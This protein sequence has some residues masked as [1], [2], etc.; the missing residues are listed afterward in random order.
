MMSNVIKVPS[1]SQILASLAGYHRGTLVFD[2]PDRYRQPY[3]AVGLRRAAT[4]V[5]VDVL[6]EP[7]RGG[8]R[9]TVRV[10]F[11]HRNGMPLDED[12]LWPPDLEISKTS[13]VVV[14]SSFFQQFDRL[15]IVMGML[16]PS[17]HRIVL[18]D[19]KE[20]DEVYG[21]F[22]DAVVFETNDD[23]EITATLHG[24]TNQDSAIDADRPVLA[25][26]N[27]SSQTVMLDVVK[28]PDAEPV[29]A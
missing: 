1:L 5:E 15:A 18:V 11:T 24:K 21:I 14:S 20:P 7:A 4:L 2:L 3:R 12:S 8:G 28:V 23:G 26:C 16:T 17:P 29:P 13:G 6:L 25:R 27:L 22:P 19:K 9:E 10:D